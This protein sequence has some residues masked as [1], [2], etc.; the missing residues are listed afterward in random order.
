M[1]ER[2]I[3]FKGHLVRKIL[4][5]KKSQTRRLPGPTNSLVDGKRDPR[6][7]A[8]LDFSRAHADEDQAGPHLLVPKKLGS[9]TYRVRPQWQIGDALWVRETW[10]VG[11]EEHLARKDP[12]LIA[13]RADGELTAPNRE[14]QRWRPGIHL[15]RWASRITLDISEVRVQRVQDI[16]A[17]DVIAEGIDV[18]DVRCQCEVC[19]HTSELCPATRT[20]IIEKFA[21]TWDAIN[22]KRGGSWQRNPWVWA[23]SWPALKVAA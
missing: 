23:M 6:L 15:P 9:A 13:Y 4:A 21:V 18:E 19:A 22:A 17:E 11:W 7:F 12:K 5:G 1:K 20:G 16:S 8:Q 3:L 2:G 14:Y 10:G